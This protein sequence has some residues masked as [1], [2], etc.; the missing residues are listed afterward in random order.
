M[1]GRCVVAGCSKITDTKNGISLHRIPFFND[2]RQEVK[3][4]R[5]KWIEFA[6]G[7]HAKW[8][9]ARSSVVCS[10]HSIPEDCAN[11]LAALPELTKA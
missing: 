2:E 10:V 7:K 11:R 1:P 6:N 4:R 3:R 8:L 9:P 5:R